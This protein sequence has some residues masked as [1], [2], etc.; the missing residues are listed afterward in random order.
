MEHLQVCENLSSLKAPIW[1]HVKGRKGRVP[2]LEGQRLT[3]AASR[4]KQLTSEVEHVLSDD[5]FLGIGPLQ[6]YHT[7]FNAHANLHILAMRRQLPS[8]HKSTT[9]KDG[10]ELSSV[11][12]VDDDGVGRNMAM[13]STSRDLIGRRPRLLLPY[14]RT[15]TVHIQALESTQAIPAL[16]AQGANATTPMRTST[17]KLTQ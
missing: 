4:R 3:G 12:T 16:P 10:T 2:T 17:R 13:R 5:W 8:L 11:R 9:N 15:Q 1:H 14:H 6:R 7:K